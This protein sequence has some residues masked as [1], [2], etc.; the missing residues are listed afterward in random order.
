MWEGQGKK[1]LDCHDTKPQV[2]IYQSG[3]SSV[4]SSSS[5]YSFR[6]LP[7]GRARPGESKLPADG[8]GA[9]GCLGPDDIARKSNNSKGSSKPQGNT[10]PLGMRVINNAEVK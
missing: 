7:A 4:S 1:G 5:G 2:N 6:E 8:V 3:K 10:G 9:P